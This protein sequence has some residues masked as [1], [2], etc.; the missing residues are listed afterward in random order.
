MAHPNDNYCIDSQYILVINTVNRGRGRVEIF[1]AGI[2]EQLATPTE[3]IAQHVE[4][5]VTQRMEQAQ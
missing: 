1:V 5:A 4:V 2:S 3:L